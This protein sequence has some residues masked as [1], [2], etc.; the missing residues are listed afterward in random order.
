M[1]AAYLWRRYQ[2]LVFV[3]VFLG[4]LLG[5]VQWT[6][7]RHNLILAFLRHSLLDRQ[8]QG[9]AVFVL[10]FT[11]GNLVQVPGWIFLASA[12]LVLG[13]VAGGLVTYLAASISC[14]VTFLS[15][16]WVGGNAVQQLQGKF[17][18]R[19]LTKGGE[20]PSPPFFYNP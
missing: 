16:R 7:L 20:I 12:V 8:W 2:R 17:A 10:L 18:S 5:V 9:L 6:G 4:A 3:L 1:N 11:L 19:L 15:V 14:V 13:Q